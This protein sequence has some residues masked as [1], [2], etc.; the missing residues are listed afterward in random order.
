MFRPA[1][2]RRFCRV[3]VRGPG[4]QE[5]L[6]TAASRAQYVVAGD[7]IPNPRGRSVRRPAMRASTLLLSA[8]LWF[9]PLTADAQGLDA[10][11]KAL[12]ATNLQSIEIQGGGSFFWVGQAY[13]AGTAWPQFNVRSLTRVINYDTASLREEMVR[14]RTLEPPRGAGRTFAASTRRW[15]SS[16]VITPGTSWATPRRR[17]R[18]PSRTGNSSSGRPRTASSRP[19]W[20]ARARSRGARSSSGS[21]AASRQPRPSTP[22]TWSSASRRRWRIPSW[23]TCPS[24]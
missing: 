17:R 12:G 24:R 6:D 13:T 18:S 4:E 5:P 1:A 10:V 16:V 21:L 8:I 2:P 11:A 3:S 14:T 22:P 19:R 9:S 15:P 23:A 20:R 7:P